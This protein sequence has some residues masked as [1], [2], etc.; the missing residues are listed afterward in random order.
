LE[1]STSTHEGNA[2]YG[3]FK[4]FA[5]CT[6]FKAIDVG[7]KTFH[8]VWCLVEVPL[9]LLIITTLDSNATDLKEDKQGSS[10]FTSLD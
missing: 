7:I 2:I 9:Y 3:R 10:N 4:S 8:N 6:S 5:L 1:S